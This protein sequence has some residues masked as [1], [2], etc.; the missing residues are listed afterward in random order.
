MIRFVGTVH[1][2]AA[3]LLV[4]VLLSST[5]LAQN[6]NRIDVAARPT[7]ATIYADQA[8]V[9]RS[10]SVDLPAGDSIL[11]ISGVPAGLLQD[12][13]NARGQAT[14]RVAIGAVEFR[15]ASFDN[16]AS[17]NSRRSELEARA[18]ELDDQ[19]AAIDV[20]QTALAAQQPMIERFLTAYFDSLRRPIP[21]PNS[22][23]TTLPRFPDDP[24]VWRNVMEAVRQTSED[25]GA[26]LLRIR[27]M[28]R[29]LEIRR[30]VLQAEIASLGARPVQGVF[31][32]AVS[33]N[34]EA[35]TRFDLAVSYQV[36]GASW[37]PVYEA[38][39]DTSA[40]RVTLRQEAIVTQSTG[41]DWNDVAI[42]LSTARPSAGT[43]PPQLSPIRITLTP[44]P[45]PPVQ[46]APPLATRMQ[47]ARPA[48][49]AEPRDDRATGEQRREADVVSANINS[50]GFTVEYAIPGTASVRA[51]GSARRVRIGDAPADA[52]LTAQIIP[53]LDRRAFLKA[54]FATP[55][56]V[57]LLPGQVSLVLD[58]VLVGR[59]NLPLLRPSEQ[60]S[61]SFGADDRIRVAYDQR[62]PRRVEGG[63]VISGR[64]TA[65]T[66]ESLI[67]VQSFH[68]QPIE[69]MVLDHAPVSTEETLTVAINAEP[70]PTARDLDDRPGVLAWTATYQPREE[71]RIR[72]GYTV[73]A[74]RDSTVYGMP[75]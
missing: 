13:L 28:R 59:T 29:D 48:G 18:R 19:I 30:N 4:A 75:R 71:R 63:N 44:P 41:E 56:T 73:T 3:A 1:V 49:S 66:S 5:A 32:I 60:T 12:S 37:R 17:N 61:L 2:R 21:I 6:V 57:P 50:A 33:V 45:P 31:E 67:T 40:A 55:A 23:E 47:Q 43:Q 27:L 9:T 15:Q 8:T 34:A 51:D 36:R 11:V 14:G 7:A 46:A 65:I 74:P 24:A 69:V 22:T 20:R 52:A 58:G 16:T 39:L 54:S 10:A 72:F 35:P 64:T 26:A 25:T 70:A 62:P 42:V 53:R 68:A 38:R